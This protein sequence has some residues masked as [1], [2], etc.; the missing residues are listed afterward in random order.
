MSQLG[1]IEY[2]VIKESAKTNKLKNVIDPALFDDYLAPRIGKKAA[3]EI[4]ATLDK[5]LLMQK[6]VDD[7]L[8]ITEELN[9]YH[10]IL[11]KKHAEKKAKGK[12]KA[13]PRAK[14][15]APKKPAAKADESDEPDDEG[16]ED[17]VDGSEID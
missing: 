11:T 16:E 13:K 2:E 12:G 1:E 10:S 14:K 3:D 7:L 17:G 5:F 9:G 8:K 15:K 6:D 4:K